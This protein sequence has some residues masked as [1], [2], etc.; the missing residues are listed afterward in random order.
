MFN[1]CFCH[2]CPWSYCLLSRV[3][4]FDYFKS[5]QTGS[6]LGSQIWPYPDLGRTDF[7]II[8]QYASPDKTLGI[9]NA[10]SCYKDAVQFSVSFVTSL[11]D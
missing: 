4:G 1:C 11:F 8:E 9:N 2:H 3:T 6:D 7:G 5:G 10:V